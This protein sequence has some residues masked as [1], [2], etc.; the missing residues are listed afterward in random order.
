MTDENAIRPRSKSERMA[1]VQGFAEAISMID[2]E[3]MPAAVD[4]LRQMAELDGLVP[5]ENA[6][7]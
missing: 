5:R 1:Y 2:K 3:G 7:N 6:Q 4:W